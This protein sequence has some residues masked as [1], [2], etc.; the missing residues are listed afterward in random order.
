MSESLHLVDTT[1]FWSPTGGGVRRYLQTKHE[2]L[3]GQP[4][5]RHTI[6]VPRVASAAGDE[7]TQPSVALPG[8]GGYRL[9]LR[10]AAIARVL[11][12]LAPDIIEAGDPYRVAW[13]ARDA[14]QGLGVPAVAYCHSNLV[15][16]ARLAAGRRFG[17]AAA[18]AAE[19]YARHVYAGFDLVLAPSR[20]MAAHLGGWGIARVACQP[21]G[22]DTALF[23]PSRRDPAWRERHGYSAATRLLVYAGRFAPEKHLDVLVDAVRRLGAPYALLAIG[24]GPT[25]PPAGERISVLPFV[26]STR[27][28]ATALASADVFV[29]AGDQ[30]TFGLSVLEAM[31]CGTPAIVRAAEGLGELVDDATGSAVEGGSGADFAAAVAALFERNR[32][33]LALRAAAARKR[34][35]AGDWQ[36]VLPGFVAHYLRLI[37][38][39]A[40]VAAPARRDDPVRAY[41]R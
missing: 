25:P 31:A 28:L 23:H 10:R 14:A 20:S 40:A 27:E 1:M 5:W 11:T 36:R 32:D 9:P 3:A 7:A 29:H 26:A 22:V 2:W 24:A 38:E 39:A 41:P 30:E 6:A 19:R 4:R 16:L 13:A 21:L 18:R 35:E 15:A 34:A 12:A 17:N 33:A 8:S 37:G